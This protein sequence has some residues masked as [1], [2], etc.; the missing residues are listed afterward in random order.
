[1]RYALQEI[2]LA[3]ERS[4][5]FSAESAKILNDD[6]GS[7]YRHT[8][9][10]ATLGPATQS[11]RSLELLIRHGVDVFRLNMAH[12]TG[13]W[14]A[15]L[16]GRIRQASDR[17]GRQVA[18]MMDV[19]GPEIRTGDLDKP[20]ALAAGDRLHLQNAPVVV[21]VGPSSQFAPPDVRSV[22]VNYSQLSR[23]VIVDGEILVDS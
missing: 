4:H 15:E 16:V 1:M 22:S 11:D 21:G 14:A 13:P 7:H 10:I 5:T 20:M 12:C 19:K 8:K 17:V 2:A 6:T 23:D 18:V 3:F 9:I